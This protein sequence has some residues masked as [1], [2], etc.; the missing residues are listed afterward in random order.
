[1]VLE[2]HS[3]SL[4]AQ[5]DTQLRLI[6]DRYLA[7][8]RERR[9]IEATYINSLRKLHLKAKTVDASFD[10][11][12]EPSSTTRVA[13]D[14]VRDS[15]EK[16]ANTQ[17]AFVDILDKDIIKLLTTLKE[18]NDEIRKRIEKDLK[19]SAEDYADYAEN[20]V[21]KLQQAYLEEY[22]P[23]Q[24][25]HSPDVRRPQDVPNKNFGGKVSAGRREDLQ[26]AKFEEVSDDA[27]R[28][29]VCQ[30]NSLRLMRAEDLGDGYDCLQELAFTPTVKN[31][32]VK[33]M[34]VQHAQSLATWR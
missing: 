5:F 29:A 8:F 22:F 25:A 4:L 11:R 15:L 28:K 2:S 12:S 33:Y 10:P 21:L 9:S 31:V 26:T 27:C 17:Q 13:W 23:Q 19:M 18:S 32:L 1:V 14:T 24:F 6:A 7:F 34:D 16:E 3:N 30:L 20:G